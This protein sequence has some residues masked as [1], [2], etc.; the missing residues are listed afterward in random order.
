[1]LNVA[2]NRQI[3][4]IGRVF[5]HV[6]EIDS[7]PNR[8]CDKTYKEDFSDCANKTE[9]CQIVHAAQNQF[10]LV[11]KFLL[12]MNRKNVIFSWASDQPWERLA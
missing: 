9:K 11:S 2:Q 1:M 5:A 6:H 7:I 3:N 10:T 8:D 12:V 4:Q